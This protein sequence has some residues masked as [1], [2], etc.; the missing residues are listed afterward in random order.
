MSSWRLNDP[1]AIVNFNRQ[2]QLGPGFV[3]LL[4]F[5]V[6]R[7]F[8]KFTGRI[9]QTSVAVLAAAASDVCGF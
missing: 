5:T 6:G 8:I 3:S 1:D 9:G 7:S 4:N 2:K